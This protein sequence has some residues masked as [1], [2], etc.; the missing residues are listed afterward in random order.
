MTDEEML[1]NTAIA[2]GGS[3]SKK[4][5]TIKNENLNDV[6]RILLWNP[7]ENS[8]EAL[9]VAVDLG[10]RVYIYNGGGD[11]CT[12]V[13][14]DELSNTDVVVRI[15]HGSDRLAATRHAIVRAAALIGK[16]K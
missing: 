13:A 12:V 1:E 10:L 6:L 15:E 7:L 5:F 8:E 11:D 9:E 3:Y 2:L 14:A 4:V 16:L